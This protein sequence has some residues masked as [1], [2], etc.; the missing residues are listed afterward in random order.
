MLG[1]KQTRTHAQTSTFTAAGAMTAETCSCFLM[2]RETTVSQCWRSVYIRGSRAMN[3]SD[4][5]KPYALLIT[6]LLM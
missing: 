5:V 3:G 2:R 4:L 6:Q 1:K